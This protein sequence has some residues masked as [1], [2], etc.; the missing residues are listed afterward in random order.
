MEKRAYTK[1]LRGWWESLETEEDNCRINPIL[2]KQDPAKATLA[3]SKSSNEMILNPEDC[4]I[5]RQALQKFHQFISTSHKNGCS[6]RKCKF[7]ST[8]FKLKTKITPK[9][10]FDSVPNS[11]VEIK[12][13]FIR[14]WKSMYERQQIGL[15]KAAKGI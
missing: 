12:P 15:L 4:Y 9:A 6:N 1:K 7:K 10:G 3:N 5:I 8:S 11:T 14:K 2:F 13:R